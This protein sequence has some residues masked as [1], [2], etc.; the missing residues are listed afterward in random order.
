MRI[1]NTARR[2]SF[3]FLCTV[4]FLD[5]IV[6]GV[7]ALRIP[8]VYQAVGAVLFG[9]IVVSAWI[10]GARLL[11][12][13]AEG[14]RRLAL[15]GALLLAP[16]A[17]VSLLWVG[18]SG[19]WEATRP[20][21]KMRYLVLLVGAIA[22]TGAF[23]LLKDALSAAG[24]SFYSSLGFAA[25]M[26]A[27]PAYL[28]WLTLQVG[29]RI[30]TLPAGEL[31]PWIGPIN[32]VLDVVLFIAGVLTYFA[33]AAFAASFGKNGWLGRGATR[34]Y[35]IMNFV[36]LLFLV[37]RGLTF[38]DVT[39]TPWFLRPGFIVGVPAVPWIMPFLLG[40]VLLRR[41]GDEQV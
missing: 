30:M 28:I 12:S 29:T 17:M 3:V 26:L 33:T 14:G 38:P 10:L 16:W 24:E 8:G 1:N 40:V 35:V 4:P 37:M 22:V 31:P 27:G 41:A 18:L 9:A 11:R 2:V 13:S 20:E 7:R 23:V 25:N 15:S 6:V 19:P 39:A 34:A 5:F 32:E 36:A 21:N